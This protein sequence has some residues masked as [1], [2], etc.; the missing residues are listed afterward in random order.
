MKGSDIVLEFSSEEWAKLW[1]TCPV[2]PFA[3]PTLELGTS[4]IRSRSAE[5]R[6]LKPTFLMTLH[7]LSRN[8]RI[9]RQRWIH[10]L[11]YYPTCLC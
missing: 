3:A 7:F 4:Q 2:Q 11:Y 8:S 5:H 6:L 1:D 10:A 9:L